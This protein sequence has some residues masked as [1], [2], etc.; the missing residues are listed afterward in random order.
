L[1]VI[2]PACQTVNVGQFPDG[3][4]SR[5]QY[6]EGVRGISVLF[7]HYAMV[8]YDKTQKI[9]KDVFG[10]PIRAGTIANHVKEFAHKSKP[11]LHEIAERLKNAAIVHCDETS[12]RVNGKKQWLHTASNVEATYSTIH[13][14]R[15]RTGTDDNGVLK[16]FSGTAVHDCWKSYFSYENCAH[17]LCNAHLLRELQGVVDNTGQ[18][19]ASE[20]QKILR[21][22]KEVVG[23]YK[24]NGKDK[25]SAYYD[26][27]F[28]KEYDRIIKFGE[29]ENPVT[30]EKK[31]S[32]PRCLLDRFITYQTEIVRFANDFEVPFDNNQAERDIR[33]AKVKQKVS[34]GFRSGDGA[35][36]FG[37]IS[38]VIG[39]AIKQGLSAF[40]A[41]SG[42]LSGTV[43][44]MFQTLPATE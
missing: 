21:E 44:S 42:I 25:L 34:G 24:E 9:L 5:A 7:T 4:S 3:I 11:A 26:K 35:K 10:I 23:C 27:K 40:G 15:G 2:C 19:W 6:G 30:Y 28:A 32:K 39:T 36:N 37:K 18:V 41:V 33:N 29:E 22:M 20:M 14:K 16:E 17:A 31:R 1:E 12:L 13:P 8:G 38:S 43:V